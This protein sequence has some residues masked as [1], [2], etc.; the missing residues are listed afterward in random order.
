MDI[1][2]IAYLIAAG[3]VIAAIMTFI[4]D[5][6]KKRRKSK[7][8]EFTL[9]DYGKAEITF[10]KYKNRALEVYRI[11]DPDQR[12]IRGGYAGEFNYM[13]F[14]FKDSDKLELM[15]VLTFI[16][17]RDDPYNRISRQAWFP[18]SLM[19]SDYISSLNAEDSL[20]IEWMRRSF[21]YGGGGEWKMIARFTKPIDEKF[22]N[23]RWR[24]EK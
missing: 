9:L 13:P 19:N 14:K 23:N 6:F 8:L 11:L 21:P 20:K 22:L 12:L 16:S 7:D 24:E 17:D 3:C 18:F 4:Y 5:S 10:Q 1:A 2:H 15:V